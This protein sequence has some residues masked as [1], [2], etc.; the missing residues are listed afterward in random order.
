MSNLILPPGVEP[1]PPAFELPDGIQTSIDMLILATERGL[2]TV[3]RKT[4]DDGSG[5]T[6]F[7][8]CVPSKTE[9]LKTVAILVPQL[10]QESNEPAD[11]AA[12]PAPAAVD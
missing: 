6:H 7:H 8:L 12:V 5:T 10:T 1:P 2:L 3:A 11:P 9:G 4:T